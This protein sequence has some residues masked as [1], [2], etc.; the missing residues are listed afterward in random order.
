MFPEHYAAL[1]PYSHRAVLA[2]RWDAYAALDAAE[3]L[4]LM[5]MRRGTAMVGYFVGMIQPAL[6]S[7]HCLECAMDMFWTDPSIR[8]GHAGMA[9]FAAV[10]A[11]LQRRGVQRWHVGSQACAD[12]SA[13]FRRLG[14]EPLETYY[15]QWIGA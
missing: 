9:L 10:R 6:H 15:T 5:T 13:L 4:F 1:A 3:V 2:P 11:E 7:R 14:M 12:A 8:N